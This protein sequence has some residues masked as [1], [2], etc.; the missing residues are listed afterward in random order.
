MTLGFLL[1]FLKFIPMSNLLKIFKDMKYT[2][3]LFLIIAIACIAVFTGCDDDKN[4]N[5]S[6]S[7]MID[8]TEVDI[9][10]DGGRTLISINTSLTWEADIDA[11]WVQVSPVA[12]NGSTL[13][14]MEVDSLV[15]GE[16]RVATVNFTAGGV[17]KTVYV[18]QRGRLES[19]YHKTG[20]V[21]KL[22]LH[23]V[24]TGISVVIIGD[25]FDREDCRIG[26]VYEYN[27]RKL[28]DLFLAMPV[29][30]DFQEYFDIYARVDVSWERGARNCVDNLDN[31]PDNAYNIGRNID[32]EKIFNN[33]VNT[34]GRVDCSVIFMGNGGI[35]GYA[36]GAMAAYS[37]NEESK[38]YWMMH[39]FAGHV[40]GHLPDMYPQ[41]YGSAPL[42]A[43]ARRMID[44]NHAGGELLMLDYR[45]DP[46]TVYWSK[47]IG[48]EGYE[49]VGVFDAGYYTIKHPD[50]TTCELRDNV[51]MCNM[52]PHF[53]VMERY[54]I[55]RQ[56]QQRA[57]FTIFTMD[58]FIDYDKVNLGPKEEWRDY[59]HVDWSDAR[60]W[61]YDD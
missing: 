47:F 2:I 22:H 29:I 7:L 12:G 10:S 37:A 55:W 57:G 9:M 3:N 46:N 53:S 23:T 48:K 59:A 6:S 56:I 54:Q 25:G 49:E 61:S 35:G 30:R 51:V 31:C 26:G 44:D 60:I 18:L 20:D 42:D 27:A 17:T 34:A 19:N 36:M 24:G 32:E 1:E 58:A 15:K 39:E 13:V 52:V 21:L 43:G 5:D 45:N 28:A 33:A 14:T 41:S 11:D 38:P 40:I 8:Q 16:R 50:L 4:T